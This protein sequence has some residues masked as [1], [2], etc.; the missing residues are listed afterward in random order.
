MAYSYYLLT[1]SIVEINSYYFALE[2][3]DH[4]LFNVSTVSMIMTTNHICTITARFRADTSVAS[5]FVTQVAISD[6]IRWG[7]WMLKHMK[8][9]MMWVFILEIDEVIEYF[10]TSH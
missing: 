7:M 4:I 2:L 5:V 10:S 8:F 3:I 6:L 1:N 9:P